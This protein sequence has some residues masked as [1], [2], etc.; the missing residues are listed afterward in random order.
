MSRKRSTACSASV[1]RRDGTRSMRRPASAREFASFALSRPRIFPSASTRRSCSIFSS[2][3]CAFACETTKRAHRKCGATFGIK[4]L[5]MPVTIDPAGFAAT[6]GSTNLPEAQLP[7]RTCGMRRSQH[8][9]RVMGA[10]PDQPRGSAGHAPCRRDG[11]LPHAGAVCTKCTYGR[12]PRSV[13]AP[14][15]AISSKGER[16]RC[17]P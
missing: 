9:I 7:H 12:L 10:Q 17:C 1:S 15:R 13:H 4:N 8:A 16:S 5:K 3:P 6:I 11:A 2:V 14:E